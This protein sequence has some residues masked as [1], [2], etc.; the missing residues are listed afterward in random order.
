MIP[1]MTTKKPKYKPF[2]N[3][4][5]GDNLLSQNLNQSSPNIVWISDTSFLRAGL[6]LCHY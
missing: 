1:A 5:I 4:S 6:S 2:S 3:H